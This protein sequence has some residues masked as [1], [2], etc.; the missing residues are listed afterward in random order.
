MKVA[1]VGAGI[2]GLTVAIALRR[3]GFDVD[4]FE[5]SAEFGRVG[6]G[7]SIAPNAMRVYQELGIAERIRQEGCV[8]ARAIIQDNTGRTLSSVSFERAGRGCGAPA[9]GI[10]RARL[11]QL[12]CDALGVD[13]I[14]PGCLVEHIDQDAELAT[15]HFGGGG[16]HTCDLVVAADGIQSGIR[17]RL[18]GPVDLRD[19]GQFCWRGVAQRRAL[20]AHA[21]RFPEDAGVEMWGR[22][23]RFGHVPVHADEVYW[24]A[25]VSDD[26]L[27]FAGG[28]HAALVDCF[29]RHFDPRV[30]ALI[31]ATE[32]ET[33]SALP[34]ADIMPARHWANG[35]CVLL[36][37]AIHPTTPNMGQGACMAVESAWVLA[38]EL[39][40]N[41][42][43]RDAFESY[44]STRWARTRSVTERSLAFGKLAQTTSPMKA[45]VRNLAV[46]LL[47]ARLQE[48]ALA[49]LFND[50][51]I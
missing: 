49:T 20:G 34:L 27:D 40:C 7:I 17:R 19:A 31:L 33:I 23:A 46:R 11:H 16:L 10:H 2:G 15:L 21:D 28:D 6:A 39:A 3:R 29:G 37:D 35:R 14:H 4:V 47:P 22:G 41:D 38:R 44:E 8:L 13:V 1:V 25:T 9:V 51:P 42:D 26:R 36:G 48:Y 45:S 24:Y 18:F 5:R 32:E 30:A 50:V 12:L 43:W